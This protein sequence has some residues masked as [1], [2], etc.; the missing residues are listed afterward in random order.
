ME[1]FCI[2]SWL[3]QFQ[4]N[5]GVRTNKNF[6]GGLKKNKIPRNNCPNPEKHNL[7]KVR[8]KFYVL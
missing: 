7:G 5:K 4:N 1:S 6:A 2:I 3:I 8:G